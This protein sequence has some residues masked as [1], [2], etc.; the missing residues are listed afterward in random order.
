MN[1]I[2]LEQYFA[3]YK[4]SPDITPAV[5]KNAE[6]LLNAVNEARRLASLDGV[7][8]EVNP[9]TGN[10][11]SGQGNGGFREQACVV[12][13]PKSTHKTGEGID[14][15]DLNTQFARWCYTNGRILEELGLTMED[16]RWTPSW[17][18]LQ[19]R[20]PGGPE[21]EWRLDYIPNTTTP[22]CKPL[23]EQG[24]RK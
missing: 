3:K 6:K 14:N 2:T 17:V 11:I 12:G 21:A 19:S 8:F 20:P 13:A 5:R 22:L 23:P 7:Q 15:Y 18:H 16:H 24:I 9:S 10:Y 4:D 1:P